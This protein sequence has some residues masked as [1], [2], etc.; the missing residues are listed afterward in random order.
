[1][2]VIFIICGLIGLWA[3]A[4]LVSALIKNGGPIK[5][6]KKWLQAIT[7]SP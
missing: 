4:C 2:Y 6:F 3:L 7:G 5:L 1:M